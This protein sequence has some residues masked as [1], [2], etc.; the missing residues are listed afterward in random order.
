MTERVR[1]APFAW[2]SVAGELGF[3]PDAAGAEPTRDGLTLRRDGSWLTLLDRT[4]RN[5]SAEDPL[6]TPGLWRSAAFELPPIAHASSE[7]D[8][9][10][11]DRGPA[12]RELIEWAEATRGTGTRPDW[13]SPDAEIL[14][15]IPA[16]RLA[17]RA[18]GHVA[19]GEIVHEPR[20]LAIVF[21]ELVRVPADLPS[22]RTRWLHQLCHDAQQRWRLARV[23]LDPS[24]ERISAEI[25]LTGVPH[26]HVRPLLR[27]SMEALSCA[28]EWAL[29][30]LA[31]VVD[32]TVESRL[33][34]RE[35]VESRKKQ[36]RRR[37]RKC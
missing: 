27:L 11:T 9:S 36:P 13:E 35:P 30:S 16:T 29:P 19:H 26:A 22:A 28:V 25:D 2:P 10:D 6:G 21:P 14:D 3:M 24:S 23:C 32:A 20:R 33:L 18:M 5:G 17:V 34:D 7:D 8:E 12:F 4:R 31:L 37:T 1:F 15:E